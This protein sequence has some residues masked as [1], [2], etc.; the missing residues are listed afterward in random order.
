MPNGLI[1]KKC[2][3]AVVDWTPILYEFAQEWQ[4]YI[5]LEYNRYASLLKI[6]ACTSALL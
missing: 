3:F 4:H 1:N 6:K 5:C 2:Y